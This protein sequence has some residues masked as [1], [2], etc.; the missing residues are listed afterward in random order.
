MDF[1]LALSTFLDRLPKLFAAPSAQ[2]VQLSDSLNLIS[3]ALGNFADAV[4]PIASALLFFVLASY[5]IKRF[6]YGA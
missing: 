4:F 6:I 2:A 1:S 3:T 5:I